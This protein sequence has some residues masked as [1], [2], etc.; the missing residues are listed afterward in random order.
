MRILMDVFSIIEKTESK[1]SSLEKKLRL[2]AQMMNGDFCNLPG[3]KNPAED[4]YIAFLRDEYHEKLAEKQKLQSS[5]DC[6]LDMARRLIGRIEDDTISLGLQLHMVDNLPW[7]AVAECLGVPDIRKRCE[8][9]LNHHEE[10]DFY[11]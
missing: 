4:S 2:L 6:A 1:L 7:R 5:L 9:Y 3:D 8:D 10:E 11:F